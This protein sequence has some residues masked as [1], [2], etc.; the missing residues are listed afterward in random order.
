MISKNMA[1]LI[2]SLE[3]KKHRERTG[4]FVAEGPKIVNNLIAV[5]QPKAIIA[6]QE[7]LKLNNTEKKN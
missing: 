3:S 5:S 7:W 6:T 2:R 4:L 1:K